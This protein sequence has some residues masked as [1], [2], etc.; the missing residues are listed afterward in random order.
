MLATTERSEFRRELDEQRAMAAAAAQQAAEE[1][2]QRDFERRLAAA[3][4][5]RPRIAK[6][7]TIPE[8]PM[9]VTRE[10]VEMRRQF[11]EYVL[12]LVELHV[13]FSFFFFVVVVVV[14]CCLIC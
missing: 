8:S 7:L 9:L 2:A 13:S 4:A 3:N 10:R 1:H 12:L 6:P 11:E 5:P 14:V